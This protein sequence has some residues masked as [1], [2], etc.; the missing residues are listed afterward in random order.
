MAKVLERIF[1]GTDHPVLNGVG[2]GSERGGDRK[3]VCSKLRSCGRLSTFP[4]ISRDPNELIMAECQEEINE[5]SS[6]VQT[7]L[8]TF[9]SGT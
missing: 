4:H 9:T 3:Q 7:M 6:R 5:G 1:Q 8:C 2:S